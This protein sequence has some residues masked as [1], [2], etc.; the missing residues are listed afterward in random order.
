MKNKQIIV[1]IALLATGLI[2]LMSNSAFNASQ[3]SASNSSSSLALPSI[4][5]PTLQLQQLGGNVVSRQAW[6]VLENY[7]AFAQA[8]DLIG[9]KSLSH[10]I[11]DTCT[12]PASEAACF[13]LMDNLYEVASPLEFSEFKHLQSDERQIIMYT[14]GPVVAILY[15]TRDQSGS[16]KILG[17]G[18]C[19]EDLEAGERCVETNPDR[20]DQDNNGWWDSIENLFY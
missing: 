20:R 1:V 10:Q 8:H 12:D 18:F 9:I 16:P 2:F 3:L 14:D 7:L 5:I 19:L 6:T 17:L 13:A 11:S 4:S 15:F